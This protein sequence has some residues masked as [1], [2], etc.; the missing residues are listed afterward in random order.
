[1]KNSWKECEQNIEKIQKEIFLIK[2]EVLLFQHYAELA[3]EAGKVLERDPRLIQFFK[4]GP[5]N[6]EQPGAAI[7]STEKRNIEEILYIATQSSRDTRR[8]YKR[9]YYQVFE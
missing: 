5:F 6:R 3:R 1:M 9:I 8:S 4:P 7:K 2:S